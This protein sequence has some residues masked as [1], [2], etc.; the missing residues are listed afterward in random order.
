MTN[1]DI[2]KAWESCS[3]G[4]CEPCPL[5]ITYPSCDEVLYRKTKEYIEELEA[6]NERL[7]VL[8]DLGNMRANDYRA[9]RD[10]C[11]TAKTEAYKEFAERLRS[12]IMWSPKNHICITAKDVEE[13]L[14]GLAGDEE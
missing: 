9:M 2:K 1:K 3:N 11:K 14:Q 4:D 7:T 13:I 5:Q 8:A 6:E 10:K 12:I